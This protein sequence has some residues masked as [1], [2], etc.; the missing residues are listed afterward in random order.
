M[1][2]R[3]IEASSS[4]YPPDKKVTPGRAGTMVLESVLTVYQAISSFEALF[5]QVAPG[6]IML[7][8]NRR[9]SIR[10]CWLKSSCMTAVKTLSDTSAHLSIS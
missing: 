6:V 9:P 1:A 2:L 7:G 3:F 8:F 4:D 10:R 5:G